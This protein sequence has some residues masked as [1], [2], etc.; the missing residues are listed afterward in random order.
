MLCRENLTRIEQRISEASK[1]IVEAEFKLQKLKDTCEKEK[2]ILLQEISWY[3]ITKLRL[4][5]S[6]YLL[7]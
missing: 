3:I 1:N 4:F 7:V 6:I 5:F 2:V